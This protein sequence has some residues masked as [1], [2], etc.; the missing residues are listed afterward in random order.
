M[1]IQAM[2]VLLGYGLG[3]ILWTVA[4][5]NIRQRN[6]VAMEFRSRNIPTW[7][8]WPVIGVEIVAGA[9]LLVSAL[10]DW[11]FI[12]STALLLGSLLT[13]LLTKWYRRMWLSVPLLAVS[14][15]GLAWWFFPW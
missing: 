3:L 1:M 8:M 9:L 13:C 6:Y 4:I 2:V 11:G 10:Q 15:S 14:L 7:F 12:L 5:Y